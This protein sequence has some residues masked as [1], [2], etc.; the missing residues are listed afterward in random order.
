M[1]GFIVESL[2]FLAF[3]IGLFLALELTVPVSEW[4]FQNSSFFELLSILV[5]IALF[6]LLSLVIKAGAKV[7]KGIVD[8]TLFGAVDNLIGALAGTIK[9]AFIM[10]IIFWVFDSVGYNIKERYASDT[11]IFP[12]IVN[13]GP[14]I[15]HW[16]SKLLPF[17]Q[18]LIDS[19]ENMSQKSNELITEVVLMK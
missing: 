8:T 12:Y 16:L 4:F 19:L 11:I 14:E 10:S 7:I 1:R 9:W 3:F 6:V 15:F 2:S 18:D 13:I 5:F 17:V